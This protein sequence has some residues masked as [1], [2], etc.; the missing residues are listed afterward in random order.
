MKDV[1]LARKKR[2]AHGR[3]NQRQMPAEDEEV[4]PICQRSSSE[5]MSESSRSSSRKSASTSPPTSVD[6]TISGAGEGETAP[7]ELVISNQA[8]QTLNDFKDLD[9][10]ATPLIA[11]PATAYEAFRI[12]CNFDVQDLSAL[13]SF[14]IGK[15]V[16]YALAQS[17]H[18]LNTLLGHR[19]SSYLEFIPSRYGS[20]PYFDAA[21]ECLAARAYS[22]LRPTDSRSKA[23]ALRSYAKALRKLQEAVADEEACEDENLLAAVQML[24]LREIV[25][26]SHSDAYSSHIAGSSRLVRHRSPKG[27]QTEYEQLIFL[28]HMGPAFTEAMYR[29]EACYLESPEWMRL[30]ESFVQPADT[31]LSDRSELVIRIR[32]QMLRLNGLLIDVTQVMDPDRTHDAFLLLRTELVIRQSH[33]ILNEAIADYKAHVVRTSIMSPPAS[34]FDKRREIYGTALECLLL[35]KRMLGT[36]CEAQRLP[37]EIETLAHAN[38]LIRLNKH[39]PNS[40]YS[41]I[42]TSQ[43]QGLA[44]LILLTTHEWS[45]ELALLSAKEKQV[46]S[47]ERWNRMTSYL[48]GSAK[49]GNGQAG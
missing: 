36:L 24:G 12:N 23:F 5:S 15:P 26:S 39:Q 47:W 10:L 3:V 8:H 22:A 46:E 11:N 29:H 42:Y 27:F 4:P 21:V 17:P 31:W 20:K 34:E 1:G 6:E 48:H 19:V 45:E 16:L 41:W 40:N 32:L 33:K 35:Y 38:E 25:D 13:T 14:H 37:L 18:L 9:S 43:E 30:Y 49:H 2:N 28:A 44:Q 7:Y